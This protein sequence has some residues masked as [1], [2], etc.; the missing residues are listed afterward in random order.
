MKKSTKKVT[1]IAATAIICVSTL[2]G[3]TIGAGAKAVQ[4]TKA[5]TTSVSQAQSSKFYKINLKGNPT[6]GFDWSYEVSSPDVIRLV[7]KDYKSDPHNDGAMGVGGVYTYKFA[8]VKAG[9][10]K[11]TFKYSFEGY[12][13]KKKTVTLHVDSKKNVTEVKNTNTN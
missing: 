5:P 11:V 4:A 12:T 7:S 10:V 1:T 3:A 2:A 6:T 9:D 8:G 13:V